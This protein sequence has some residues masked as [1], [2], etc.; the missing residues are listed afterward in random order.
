MTKAY[1]KERGSSKKWGN[2]FEKQPKT[3]RGKKN[4]EGSLLK[5][6]GNKLK[7]KKPKIKLTL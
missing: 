1:R 2:S 4:F 3:L 7:N 6:I 5:S